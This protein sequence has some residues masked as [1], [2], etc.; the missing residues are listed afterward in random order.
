[1][2][3]LER[4]AIA[5][6]RIAKA[7]DRTTDDIALHIVRPG[8]VVRPVVSQ[9]Y[10]LYDRPPMTNADI[11]EWENDIRTK[12]E[13]RKKKPSV[14]SLV[15]ELKEKVSE[16]ET[17]AVATRG[18]QN[19]EKGKAR[20]VLAA[21][22]DAFQGRYGK[23][24]RPDMG[25]RVQGLVKT[26]LKTYPTERLSMLVQAYLQMEDRWFV[27]KCHDFPTFY[28]NIGKVGVCLDKGKPTTEKTWEDIIDGQG[29]VQQ[30]SGEAERPVAERLQ[31]GE[32]G[33]TVGNGGEDGRGDVP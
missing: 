30:G 27:T 32:D 29:G 24:T 3:E 6:E 33:A 23:Q 2:T 26:L 8:D 10:G 19:F 11:G 7:L 4:I 25:G 18:A 28:E 22:V 17:L 14:G 15:R 13:E 1:M 16:V 31:G 21:Y 20:L 5:L 9:S 12:Q